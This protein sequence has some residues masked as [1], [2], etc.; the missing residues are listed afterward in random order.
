[1][2]HRAGGRSWRIAGSINGS[3]VQEVGEADV[4]ANVVVVF[5]ATGRGSATIVFALTRGERA[6]VYEARRFV[7]RV[8]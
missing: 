5:K 8:T 2:P 6:K 3:I 7:V 4:G 1:M